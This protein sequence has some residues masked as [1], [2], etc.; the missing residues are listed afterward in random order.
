MII[1][2]CC[3][4]SRPRHS[5]WKN[6]CDSLTVVGLHENW[7]LA[8]RCQVSGVSREKA[9]ASLKPDTRHLKPILR[10]GFITPDNV[11]N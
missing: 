8:I 6:G 1:S 2:F 7:T 9:K 3:I 10:E 11:Q 4:I 5:A